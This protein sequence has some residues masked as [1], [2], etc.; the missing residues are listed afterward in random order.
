MSIVAGGLGADGDLVH[1]E[2]GGGVVHGAALGGGEAPQ[3]AFGRP[4]AIRVVPSTGSTAMSTSGPSPLPTC[5]PLKSIGASS[6]S[7]SPM[8]TTPLH[9]HGIDELAHRV[10]CGAIALFFLTAADPVTGGQGS[11]L[12]DADQFHREVAIRGGRISG[13]HENVAFRRF[14]KTRLLSNMPTPR[15]PVSVAALLVPVFHFFHNGGG[16]GANVGENNPAGNHSSSS[17][18]FRLFPGQASRRRLVCQAA[19]LDIS[20]LPAHLWHT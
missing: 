16:G 18:R 19:L 2:H 20:V 12:G 5:S 9:G 3:M 1:V 13:V 15:T 7:P 10:D 11:R 8:T 4:S 14:F 17:H 6:F